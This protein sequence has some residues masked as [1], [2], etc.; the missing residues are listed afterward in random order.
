[1]NYPNVISNGIQWLS[2]PYSFLDRAQAESGLTFRMALPGLGPSALLTG[3]PAMIEEI[4]ASKYLVGGKGIN[5]LQTLFGGT[6]LIMMHGDAHLT[7]RRLLATLFR[8]PDLTRY[9]DFTVQA[10]L[11]ALQNT[12]VGQPFSAF[13]V[14]RLITLR[15]ILRFVFGELPASQ[16]AEALALVREFMISFRSPLVLFLKPLHL[17]LGQ[18]SPWG[19]V[20]R[21]RRRLYEFIHRQIAAFHETPSNQSSALAALLRQGFNDEMELAAEIFALLMF[22]HDTPAVTLAWSLAHIYS[23]PAALARLREEGFTSTP[24]PFLE[25]C[26]NESMRLCPVVV[27]L[28]RVAEQDLKLADYPIRRG[29]VVMPCVYLAHHNPA[30]FPNPQRFCP[31]RFLEGQSYAHS[32]FPFGFGARLCLGKPL[33]IRQMPLI[34]STLLQH[35]GW[36][37]AP[38]YHPE[39]VR[40]M[41]LIAPR[42]GTLMVRQPILK[43]RILHAR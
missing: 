13:E 6:S 1:M 43:G 40:Y 3:D 18:Y 29:E 25:A 14:V 8:A 30:V 27:Q 21:S 36:T 24:S 34:L 15:V 41:V 16:E 31:E 33:A 17:D 2:N 39:P 12:P 26:L 20:V 28:F 19:R 32:F 37:L 4:I 10:T 23:H 22:G 35:A 42:A 38:G 11:E 5:V 7:R 9:D